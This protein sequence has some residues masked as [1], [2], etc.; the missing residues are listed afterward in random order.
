M[1]PQ[2]LVPLDGSEQAEAIIPPVAALARATHS[3][4]TLLKV[5]VPLV[6]QA[7]MA[8]TS[9]S[10]WTEE[11]ALASHDYLAGIARRLLARR[12]MVHIE[13]MYGHPAT[14]IVAYTEENPS[15]ALI[16]LATHARNGLSRF[17]LGSITEQVVRATSRPVLLLHPAHE[18]ATSL[19]CALAL[20]TTLPVTNRT[21]LVPLDGSVCAERALAPVQ[22]VATVSGATVVLVSVVHINEEK[23]NN[24]GKERVVRTVWGTVSPSAA[25]EAQAKVLR[26]RADYL[27]QKARQLRAAGVR[28][29]TE[30][31]IGEPAVEIQHACMQ[32][33]ANMVVMAVHT[34]N[35]LQR[36]CQ[37]STAV[38]IVRN[39][40]LPV[41]LV[42]VDGHEH[43]EP[44]MLV[45]QEQQ[46]Q[47]IR[48]QDTS[49]TA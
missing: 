33:H 8:W 36:I 32:E 39:V 29:R 21:I 3:V 41:M 17:A 38:D 37:S 25:I 35:L 28:V 40:H 9:P 7:P 11:E 12:V 5:N 45:T 18:P 14:N 47:N 30:V 26:I 34:H 43:T 1:Q 49:Q 27:E 16:A 15:V 10:G 19:P 6:L 13:V 48:K 20:P 4:V 31:I 44:P 42:R 46:E 2:I 22:R 23:E 24:G